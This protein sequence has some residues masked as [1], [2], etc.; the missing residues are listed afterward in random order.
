MK[1][2]IFMGLLLFSAVAWATEN[3]S[4]SVSSLVKIQKE[5]TGASL[6]DSPTYD[7]KKA[8]EMQVLYAQ[9]F[10][11]ICNAATREPNFNTESSLLNALL[12]QKTLN[13]AVIVFSLKY[14][15]DNDFDTERVRDIIDCITKSMNLADETESLDGKIK[16]LLI[17]FC[18]PKYYSSSSLDRLKSTIQQSNSKYSL[19]IADLID[20]QSYPEVKAILKSKVNVLGNAYSPE[21]KRSWISLCILARHNDKSSIEHAKAIARNI[22]N[23][24]SGAMNYVPMGLAYTKQKELIEILFEMLKNDK[25]VFNG[26]DA[27]PQKT[28]LAHEVASALSL[29]IEGFPKYNRFENFSELDK[30]RCIEWV[31]K[32][33]NNYK[34]I[35]ARAGCFLENTVLGL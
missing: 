15:K 18:E 9:K 23:K 33:K 10:K 6:I 4:E 22:D 13:S 35:D 1:Q 30:K 16:T 11:E 14:A 28:Q 7:S 17:A 27:I 31:E 12:R 21:F 20:F 8:Y 19:F 3:E 5:W 26:E 25:M 29:I 32:N 24:N 34:I 2:F